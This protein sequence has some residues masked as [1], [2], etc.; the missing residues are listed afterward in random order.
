MQRH[1]NQAQRYNHQN[2]PTVHTHSI[3]VTVIPSESPPT[4]EQERI[5][6]QSIT[7]ETFQGLIQ[8]LETQPSKRLTYD[9]GNLEIWMP[10]PPHERYKKFFARLVEVLTEEQ[11]IEICSLGSC[12]WS[13]AD[14]AKGVEADECYYIQNEPAIRGRMTIDLAIDPPPDLAIEVDMTSLSLPR[15]PIYGALGIPEIWRYDGA[16]S[17]I[18][19]W[20]I[21]E[22]Q[23]VERSICLPIV[24]PGV[25]DNF[26]AQ[27]LTMG[28]TSW[29]KSIRTWVRTDGKP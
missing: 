5:L 28:E 9:N 8:E 3:M 14:L 1:A 27:V 10:L 21:D 29:V 15:L 16:R 4:R 18:L 25:L 17:Q 20:Q 11:E 19:V 23:P 6:L 12:T 7:W 2:T 13:R 26:L 24:T 22:Y